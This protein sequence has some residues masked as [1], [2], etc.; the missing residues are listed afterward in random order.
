MLLTKNSIALNPNVYLSVDKGNKKGN[1]NLAKILCWYDQ[2]KKCVKIFIIDCDCV[3]EDITDI[4]KGIEYSLSR[5]FNGL[6]ITLKGQCT[7]I[8]VGGT[9]FAL[10]REIKSCN[11]NAN[12][13]LVG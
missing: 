12:N 13:Y 11:M 5:F 9:K 3:E 8:G 4:H 1:T 10:A 2:I 7:D 6:N